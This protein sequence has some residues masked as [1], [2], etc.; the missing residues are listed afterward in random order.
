MTKVKICGLTRPEDAALAVSEGAW[1]L[2]MIMWPG[3]PR[4]CDPQRAAE[5]A[6]ANRRGAEIVGVFVDQPLDEVVN[7]AN[8]IGLSIVQLHGD[9]GQQFCKVV[10]QR[11][12]VKVIKSFR[13]RNRSVLNEMGRFWDVDY[14]LLDSYEAGVPGGTGKVFEWDFLAENPRRGEA[15]VILSGG[16][17]P[18]NVAEAIE[19]VRPYAVDVSS[20]IETEPGVKDHDRMREFFAAARS[21]VVESDEEDEKEPLTGAEEEVLTLNWARREMAEAAAAKEEAA[22]ANASSSES[23]PTG[24]E[25]EVEN[26]DSE[27]S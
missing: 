12:G 20:G 14:H 7:L 4:H 13:V 6:D 22:R 18:E 19:T 21:V 17:K 5:I 24:D 25:P 11:A 10:A 26:K 3:S 27:T 8:E 23:T 9:E 1:A 15:P 16:L 2:G